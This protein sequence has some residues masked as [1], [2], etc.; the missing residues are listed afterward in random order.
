MTVLQLTING[1]LNG[2]ILTVN[3]GEET[4]YL[5]SETPDKLKQNISRM[6]REF[7]KENTPPSSKGRTE[8]FET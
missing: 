1:A 3:D 2:H 4:V 8:V 6:V 5:V 7:L